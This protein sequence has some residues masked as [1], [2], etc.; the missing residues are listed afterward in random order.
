VVVTPTTW[1]P[2]SQVNTTDAAVGAGGSAHQFRGQIVGLPDGG[3]FV[4]WQDT[5]RALNAGG[6]AIMGQRYD[7]L[8][9]RV[10]GEVWLTNPIVSG[11]QILPSIT[12]L[13]DGGIAVA[14]QDQLAG[15]DDILVR[16][17]TTEGTVIDN[18]DTTAATTIDPSIA[19]FADGNYVVAYTIGSGADTDIAVRAVSATGSVGA[20]VFIHD[21]PDNSL[22]PELATLSNGNFVAV[23]VDELVGMHTDIRFRIMQPNLAAVTAS[24]TVIGGGGAEDEH[25]PSVAALRDGGFVATWTELP[26]GGDGDD[27]R[28][29]IYNNAG[30]LVAGNIAI[31]TATGDQNESDVLAL[32]DGGFLVTWEDDTANFVRAQ[33]FDA[34]G[35]RVGFEFTVRNQVAQDSPEAAL[36]TSGRFA[37][38]IGNGLGADTD[39]MTSVWDFGPLPEMELI[40]DLFWR[41]IDGDV[42]TTENALGDVSANWR[43]VGYGD[44]DNDGDDD[45]LWRR[46]TDGFMV[47]WEMEDGL[48]VVNHNLAFVSSS[49]RVHGIGDFDGDG[50]DD[51]LWR[52]TEGAVVTW[53]MDDG[54]LVTTHSIEWASANWRINGVGDFDG[55]GDDDILWRHSAG[56]VVTWE[57][58]DSAFVTNHNIETASTSWQ[59]R[60]VGDFDADGDGDL[61]WRSNDGRTVIWEM[62]A[63]DYVVNHNLADAGIAWWPTFADDFDSDGDDD[64]LWRNSSG[65]IVSWEMEDAA[66][67]TT[68]RL[69][70]VPAG[71]QISTIGEAL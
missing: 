67:V 37:Y 71:W 8:G 6:S 15:D 41:H 65:D 18:L 4:V 35:N 47:T 5:S 24:T 43:I 19:S 21:E 7:E 53:E 68:H 64:I 9:A 2:T 27:I 23:F 57:M 16:R 48:F 3:Y 56:A 63:G 32:A 61:L 44:F 26:F 36:L 31:A 12:G 49:W 38:A 13:P 54:R 28:A 55:D 52:H 40:G 69:G 29:S 20:Q 30:G 39:V 25:S 14:F 59:I 42:A 58:E 62:E 1:R 10:G 17:V 70:V 46:L 50:D 51:I 33:R 66:L 22:A 60:Q 34:I 11:E 45:I